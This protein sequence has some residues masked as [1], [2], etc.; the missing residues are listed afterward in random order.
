LARKTDIRLRRSN[1][2]NA[3]P[4]AA[5]LSDGELAM[6]TMDGALYFKKSD[7]TIITGHDNTIMH[8]DSANSRV[9]IG[10]SSPGEKL[11][12]S[13]GIIRV[14]NGSNTTFYEEDKIHSYASSGLTIDGR[15]GLTLETSTADTDII[16]NPTG[17][18]GIGTDSPDALL[19]LS[20]NTGAT[21]R[22]ESTDTNIAANEVMGAIEWEGNDV[23]TGSSGIAGKIDVI[24]EDATPEYAMRFFTHDNL[25]GT[26]E[27]AERMR[28]RSDGNVGIGTATPDK[29]LTVDG[30]VKIGNGDAFMSANVAGSTRSLI[31]LGTDNILRIKG[32]DAEGSSNVIS[33]IAGGNV[34]IGTTTPEEDLHVVGDVKLTGT[35]F[36]GTRD[37]YTNS[38]LIRLNQRYTGGAVSGTSYFEQNEYQKVVTI[39]PNGS[40]ENYQVSGTYYVQSGGDIQEVHFVAG[41]RS[42]V[43]PDLTWSIYYD[44]SN[45]GTA[46]IEPFLWT[47]ETTTAGFILGFKVLTGSIFGSVTADVDIIPRNADDKDNVSINTTVQSEQ[48]TIDTG[49]TNQSFTL[50]KSVINA[51]T[52]LGANPGSY[53]LDVAGNSRISGSVS[54]VGT[55]QSYSG[56]FNIKN[57][58]QNQDL[59]L[60]VND[61]GTN[62]TALTV[63]GTTANVGI[64]TTSPNANL[65]VLS[66][67][68]G[69]IEVERASGALI[70]LQAQSARGVI[71]TDSNHDLQLKTNGGVRM[72]IDT[73]GNVGI[74]TNSPN[75][76]LHIIGQYTVENSTSPSGAFLFIPSSDANRIY[77]RVSNAST[78]SRDF[79][80]LVG[81]TEAMRIDS[82]GRV[83]IGTAS[84]LDLLHIKSTST[85]ARQVIDGHTGF[86]AELKFAEAGTVKFTTGFDAATDKFVI[87]TTNVDTQKRFT[88]D[89][90]GAI[91]SSKYR[92]N[93]S[94]GR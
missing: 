23:T 87:G 59:N 39:T 1:V 50:R 69:E 26:Y 93:F 42:G 52:G 90:N 62:T 73:G 81:S 71:G 35:L 86:D 2:A 64:G 61:G 76:N 18:V 75:R 17:Y 91:K 57:I 34:G 6:N 11:S 66:S 32:N 74:G 70:N 79:A 47:K 83:G 19:H 67:G 46:Y 43:L 31:S 68:N 77:S 36:N 54:L 80:F 29:K 22:L 9:G 88:I 45:N 65:H 89:N 53:R 27:L 44:Q 12:V 40:S 78:S 72:T 48:T 15:E 82:S 25:L 4:G 13:G 51:N 38:N 8:I 14:Q 41:L 7:G 55:L 63:Q 10:T 16:L 84:P 20:A 33:M 30:D 24:A 28:I 92:Y 60:Q 21:L 49:F 37:E 94:M 56:A 3:I 58:A 5:N 85:D